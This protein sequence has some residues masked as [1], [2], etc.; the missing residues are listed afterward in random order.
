[1]LIRDQINVTVA[2]SIQEQI[3]AITPAVDEYREKRIYSMD[4][5]QQ[6]IELIATT[7]GTSELQRLQSEYSVFR[8]EWK[9]IWNAGED[10]L[11]TWRDLKIQRKLELHEPI[12][13]FDIARMECW[14]D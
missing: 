14:I 8:A 11:E 1:M 6:Y 13:R 5:D 2:M 9:P 12:N 7:I 3:D 4:T 10:L